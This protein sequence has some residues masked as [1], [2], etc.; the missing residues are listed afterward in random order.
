[1]RRRRSAGDFRPSG[2]LQG[3]GG[4]AQLVVRSPLDEQR[5]VQR[6][7]GV[8]Q[9]S[10]IESVHGLG[11]AMGMGKRVMPREERGHVVRGG[12]LD[13]DSLHRERM[14]TTVKRRS[15]ALR[16]IASATNQSGHI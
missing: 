16:E 8:E 7:P 2:A 14:V 13:L 12:V 4:A 9:P 15:P 3:R 5:H 10:D 1:M 11:R 6:D